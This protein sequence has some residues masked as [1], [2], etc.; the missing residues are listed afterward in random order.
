MEIQSDKVMPN[1]QTDRKPKD[2]QIKKM[3]LF[4]VS[5]LEWMEIKSDKVMSNR[6]TDKEDVVEVVS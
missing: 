5:I 1:R 6:Q 3:S 4:L 2:R